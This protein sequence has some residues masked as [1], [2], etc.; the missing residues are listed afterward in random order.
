MYINYYDTANKII[1]HVTC[2]TIK[3]DYDDDDNGVFWW[4]F[5][6]AVGI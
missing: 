5:L 3:S 1:I 2:K 6:T 4:V